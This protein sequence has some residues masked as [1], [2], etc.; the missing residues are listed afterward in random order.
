MTLTYENGSGDQASNGMNDRLLLTAT[1]ALL[2]FVGWFAICA[3]TG[4]ST[5]HKERRG[6]GLAQG[7]ITELITQQSIP[8]PNPRP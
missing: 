8:T 7:P 1:I 6:R 5:L 2:A 4:E 3:M